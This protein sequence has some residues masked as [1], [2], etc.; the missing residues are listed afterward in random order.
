MKSL[1]SMVSPPIR[2]LACEHPKNPVLK[3]LFSQVLE[4]LASP[5]LTN[6][7]FE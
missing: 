2:S 7:E 6:P 4:F 1:P 5:D 3:Q